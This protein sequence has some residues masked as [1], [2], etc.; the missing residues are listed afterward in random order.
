MIQECLPVASTQLVF[1]Q[2]LG[3]SFIR[4]Y[5]NSLEILA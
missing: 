1:K 3:L 2:I 4:T 5:L